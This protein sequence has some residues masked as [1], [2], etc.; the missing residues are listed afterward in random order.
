MTRKYFFNRELSWLEFNARVLEEALDHSTPLLERL[1]FI[2]IVGSNF[3]E[4]FMIRVASLKARVRAGDV[5]RDGADLSPRETLQAVSKRVR[6]IVGRQYECLVR[7]VLPAL[8][9]EGLAVVRPSSWTQAERRWLETYFVERVAPLLTP[10]RV[11]E[12]KEFPST[13]NLRIH[14]AFLLRPEAGLSEAEARLGTARRSAADSVGT[15]A[16][17]AGAGDAASATSATATRASAAAAAGHSGAAGA[18]AAPGAAAVPGAQES[19]DRVAV[20]QVPPRL[21]RFITL[22]REG[23]GLRLALLDDVVAAFGHR[24]FPGY[25]LKESLVFRVTRDADIGVDEDRDDDFIAAME[26]I[27]V[28]R[29]NSYPVRLTVTADSE[30]LAERLR[31]SLGLE[32]EE[33][34]TLPGPVD[35]RGFM[36]LAS[37]DESRFA[38]ADRLRF[39]PW[40]PVRPSA[41]PEGSTIWDEMKKADSILHVPYESFDPVVRFLEDAAQD[42]AVLA[43]KM[44]LYRTSGNS[45]ILKALTKAAQNGK[46][47]AVLVEVKARFDEERNIAWASRLE[48]AGAIVVYGLA[49]LKVHAK[50]ALVVRREEDG[51]IRRYLHLSTGNYND[52]TARLYADLSLFTANEDLCREA[53]IFFNMVTGYSAV[54]ELRFLAVAPFD[55]K[56]RVIAMI[57]REAQRSSPESPGLVVAK[58]NALVDEE[59][60][61]ALYRASSAG[62][63]VMLNVRG[64]C[65]LVPGVKGLSENIVVVSVVGRYLEHARALYFRN[66][67]A[68]ELYLSSADWMPRNLERRIELMFPIL[69]EGLRAGLRELLLAYFRD[70]RKAHRLG[71]SGRWKKVKPAEGEAPFSAQAWFCESVKKRRR[72]YDEPAESELQVRRKPS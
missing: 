4:F 13:G 70:N 8:A 66:G 11:E 59:V 44:T 45:P 42:P 41:P 32:E 60:V 22:P 21:E 48:Q 51:S 34:Y 9:K 26:E 36:E 37:I 40:R 12:D 68:E 31:L 53:S 39:E 71:P 7:E 58:M 67:G 15:A 47:V 33:V 19:A 63:R 46:Q 3:D 38:G 1:K 17:A 50:A 16:A 43:I 10:L 27:I 49:R 29:Q 6:E 20:V 65:A 24:L 18:A 25:G 30:A 55:L 69:D 54:Q 72:V 56:S 57:E 64:V 28:D 62:V 61:S 23:E 5:L 14:A 35:L 2:A 52:K